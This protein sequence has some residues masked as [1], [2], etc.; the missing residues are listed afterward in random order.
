MKTYFTSD[1][2]FHHKNIIQFEAGR[3]HFDSVEDMN[4]EII[5][6]WNATVTDKD[7]VY[8]LGDFGMNIKYDRFKAILERLNGNIILIQG[9]H[10]DTKTVRKLANEGMIALHEVGVKIKHDRQV[11]WLSHY[12]MEIGERLRKW[13]IHGHIHSEESNMLNQINVG[14]DSPHFKFDKFCTPILLEDILKLMES[15]T[16]L[17][18]EKHGE[19]GGK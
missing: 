15:R 17:I 5:K 3:V 6:N 13:S 12:P 4:E 9:N 19:R 2:H 18:I 16:E 10:D 14:V 11:M 7:T 1:T 8:H